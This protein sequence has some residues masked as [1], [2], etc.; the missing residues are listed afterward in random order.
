MRII[1][2]SHSSLSEHDLPHYIAPFP[3]HPQLP[4]LLPQSHG[5]DPL[6]SIP[7]H[8]GLLGRLAIQSPLTGYEPNATVEI[9]CTEATLVHHAS[10]RTSFC[11][12]SNSGE[13]A[14]TAPVTS[15]VDERQR[16]RR[17][18]SPLLMQKREA[19]AIPAR[20]YHSTGEN[21]TSHHHTHRPST[22][23]PVVTHSHKRKSSR[24]MR[25]AQEKQ[26]VNERVRA[27]Q[28]DVRDFFQN[29]EQKKQSKENMKPYRDSWKRNLIRGYFL[30][31]RGVKHSQ[32]QHLRYFCR[33][34]GR[35]MQHMQY[36]I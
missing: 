7:L 1:S 19:I 24:D 26:L 21:S 4:P 9:S 28:Q 16:I 15:G 35:S 18:P 17:L 20:M 8:V 31:S 32:R 2:H 11:S 14:T 25:S 23:R 34:R 6:Q 5:E 10:R 29:S 30:T 22:G 3:E 36:K 12:A 33:R 27:E 13:D